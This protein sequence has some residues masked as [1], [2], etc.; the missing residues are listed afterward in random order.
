MLGKLWIFLSTKLKQ[1]PPVIPACYYLQDHQRA[2]H[3]KKTK[4]TTKPERILICCCSYRNIHRCS[5]VLEDG[6]TEA[7]WWSVHIEGQNESIVCSRFHL[8]RN[9]KGLVRD[10]ELPRRWP[11]VSWYRET[12]SHPVIDQFLDKE[13]AWPIDIGYSVTWGCPMR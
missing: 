2:L 13:S 10:G 11:H 8:T 1:N 5:V 7:E 12:H 9:N 6:L 3:L 4:T